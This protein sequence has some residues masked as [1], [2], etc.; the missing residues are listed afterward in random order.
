MTDVAA[1]TP[2]TGHRMEWTPE[3]ISAY[4]DWWSRRDIAADE[5]FARQVG[6]VIAGLLAEARPLAGASVLDFGCG[7]GH[8]IPHLL[9][10]GASVSAAD[11]SRGAIEEVLKRFSG[12][13]GWV[14]ARPISA[15]GSGCRAEFPDAS[16]DA[17]CC[18][19]TIEHLPERDAPAL[20]AELVRLC[21][22]GGVLL[23]TTPDEEN[24]AKSTVYC[25]EC[26]AEFHKVQHLSRWSA[27]SLASVLQAAGLTPLFCAGLDLVAMRPSPLGPPW[28]WS[29][30]GLLRAL[31]LRAA[32]IFD[33]FAPR[34]FPSGRALALRRRAGPN[35]VAVAIRMPR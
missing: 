10:A 28:Q 4:W 12:R 23:L 18:L 15:A 5:Y 21:R 14:A 9:D 16:F 25:P 29:A 20:V 35:L 34:K 1:R 3:R 24:L 33:R 8:L 30:A 31:R 13:R 27:K 6:G 26:A 17:V 19:E 32:R 11:V 7:P 2:S 22:P